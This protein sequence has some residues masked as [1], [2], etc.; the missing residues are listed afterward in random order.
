MGYIVSGKVFADQF[1]I[2][3]AGFTLDQPTIGKWLFWFSVM[4]FMLLPYMAAVRWVIDRRNRAAYLIYCIVTVIVCVSLLCVLLVPVSW[5]IQYVHTM[6]F[7]PKR[8]FGL[9]YGATGGILV[10]GFAY[11]AMRRPRKE[12]G[13][14]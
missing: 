2:V 9:M 4:M 6:G 10:I 5:L 7:T 1:D 13:A 14:I 8:M 12:E 3:H 11:W